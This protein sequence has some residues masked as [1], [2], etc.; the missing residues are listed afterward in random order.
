MPCSRFLHG[1][2]SDFLVGPMRLRSELRPRAGRSHAALLGSREISE[3][4]SG[5]SLVGPGGPSV[6]HL[7]NESEETDFAGIGTGFRMRPENGSIPPVSC[8]LQGGGIE[9]SV[10]RPRSA[11]RTATIRETALKN[12]VAKRPLVIFIASDGHY[13]NTCE[14]SRL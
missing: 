4:R 9:D 5:Q 1:A 13:V 12:C 2:S 3:V 10:H 6:L 11:E 7:P 8:R 14:R